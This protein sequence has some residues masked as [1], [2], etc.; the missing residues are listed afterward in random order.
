MRI[1]TLVI[2][3]GASLIILV[4]SCAATAADSLSGK[5]ESTTGGTGL[6]VAL[7]FICGAG[8][9]LTHPRVSATLFLLAA[10]I[11]IPVGA[12]SEFADLI[13]WGVLALVLAALEV[14]SHWR[15]SS[16]AKVVTG[17]PAQ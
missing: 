12:T 1:A 15:R 5:Q 10:V 13:V 6:I 9:A 8:F 14:G 7:L 2:G 4:Q 11:A 16:A 17:E 3:L